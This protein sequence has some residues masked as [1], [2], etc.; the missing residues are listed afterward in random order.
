M[1]RSLL[2][3][4]AAILSVSYLISLISFLA[5]DTSAAG[6]L[7]AA[8]VKP[9]MVVVAL[10]VVFN[11]LGWFLKAPWAALVA[12]ILYTISIVLIFNF[13]IFVLIQL[14]LCLIAFVKMQKR[15][16]NVGKHGNHPVASN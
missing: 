4:I 6:A 13:I 1:K 7:A 3:L 14:I 2:L 15:Q 11:L 9:H 12:G 16:I 10:A 8:L 5:S